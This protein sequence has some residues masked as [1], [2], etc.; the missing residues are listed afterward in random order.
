MRVK[1]TFLSRIATTASCSFALLLLL[2]PCATRAEAQT[3]TAGEDEIRAA[4]VLHLM[5]FV[6]WPAS[7]MDS[8]H[9]QFV[10]C[11]L[12]AD[13]I[14]PVLESVFR[15]KIVASKPVVVERHS[16]NDKLDGC[17]VLYVGFNARKDF[18]RQV[19]ALQ[20]SSVLTISERS[21]TMDAGQVIGFP[22]EEEHVK[23]E[24][25]LQSAQLSKLTISSRLLHLATLVGK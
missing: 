23:I 15:D 16:A 18:L 10:V 2:V 4:M 11:V 25:N 14:R 8:A 12:G 17:H 6:D 21:N 22:I 9:P 19:P 24:V 20:Q 3:A 7:K 13:P 1:T 5:L